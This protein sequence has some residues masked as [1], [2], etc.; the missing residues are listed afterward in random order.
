MIGMPEKNHP[1]AVVFDLD[2][3][4][5]NT[6]E[7]YQEVAAELLRRRNCLFTP[8]LLDQ[9]MGRPGRVALQLMIDHHCLDVT[10]AQLSAETDEIF[11]PILD[12]RLALMPGLPQLLSSLETARIKKAVATSSG[13]RYVSRVLGHFN[14]AP[15]FDF[16]LT[17][18]DV[19]DGKPHP[20]IYLK[21]AA[22]FGL[23]ASE[24][25][26]L[27]DSQNGCLAAAAAGAVVV[28]VPSGHS[29]RH[30]FSKAK[31]VAESLEDPRIYELLGIAL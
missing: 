22:R 12:S 29:R 31:L 11:G 28:A 18:E 5:L 27:E 13:R 2:G 20:E 14:L 23:A 1:R 7:L 6:E 4:M 16:I 9:M 24:L 19:L 15:R 3:L 17:S 8:E 10:V 30:N 25:L 21:A 26:V